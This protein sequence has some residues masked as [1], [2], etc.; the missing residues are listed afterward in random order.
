MQTKITINTIPHL[1]AWQKCLN[2]ETSFD[3]DVILPL[4]KQFDY[5]KYED[6][7]LLQSFNPAIQLLGNGVL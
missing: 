3:R 4:G 2:S 6:A 7:F 1:S 5:I